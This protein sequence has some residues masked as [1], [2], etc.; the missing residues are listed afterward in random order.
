MSPWVPKLYH[1]ACALKL[2]AVSQN[3]G[4]LF[5]GP[6]KKDYSIS[7]S[8]LGSPYLGTIPQ[9]LKHV[10]TYRKVFWCSRWWAEGIWCLLCKSCPGL[11]FDLDFVMVR[12]VCVWGICRKDSY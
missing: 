12:N 9:G 7:G 2:K 3:Q 6:Y 10:Q 11:S 5:G 1:G 4:C 8:M